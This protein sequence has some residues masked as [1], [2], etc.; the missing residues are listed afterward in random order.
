MSN[1]KIIEEFNKTKAILWKGQQ[2]RQTFS[3]D[4]TENFFK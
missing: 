3:E 2:N 1:Q 4:L